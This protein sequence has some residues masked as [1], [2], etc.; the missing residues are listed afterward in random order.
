LQSVYIDIS[1]LKIAKRV[2]FKYSYYKKMSVG[3]NTYALKIIKVKKLK[4]WEHILKNG[5]VYNYGKSTGHMLEYHLVIAN[6]AA[7]KYIHR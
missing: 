3:G 2:D 6:Y 5:R 1:Y 7:E 4:I